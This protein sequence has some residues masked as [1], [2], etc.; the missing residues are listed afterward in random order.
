M[1]ATDEYNRS[2][3]DSGD[4]SAPAQLA[5]GG[6]LATP[7][8]SAS[9]EYSR[10]DDDAPLPAVSPEPTTSPVPPA[11]E[12]PPQTA[13]GGA[14]RITGIPP[15]ETP[16]TSTMPPP[17]TTGSSQAAESGVERSFSDTPQSLQEI[18]GSSGHPPPAIGERPPLVP[19][20]PRLEPPM[21]R[22]KDL[23]KND[24]QLFQA[25]N[26]VADA[27]NVPRRDLAA[28]VYAASNND[29]NARHGNRIGYGGLTPA[30]VEWVDPD[31]AMDP[32]DP[33]DNLF[34]TAEKLK[35]LG[36]QYGRGTPEQ[37]AAYWAGGDRVN[38][39]LRRHPDDHADI[40][41]PGTF[42]FVNR[43][44]GRPEPH[45][46]GQKSSDM[47]A[48]MA[49]TQEVLGGGAERATGGAG[50][51]SV[52]DVPPEPD[53]WWKR[54]SEAVK[55]AVGSA[56]QTAQDALSGPRA[57]GSALERIGAAPPEGMPPE[58][59][60]GAGA[61]VGSA[62]SHFGQ[63][64]SDPHL[65]GEKLAEGLG[66]LDRQIGET[67]ARQEQEAQEPPA[68][69]KAIG[70]YLQQVYEGASGNYG[71]GADNPPPAAPA[72]PPGATG[73]MVAGGAL[74]FQPAPAT[75]APPPKPT[76]LIT[77][78]QAAAP[79]PP[80]AAAP[81]PVPPIAQVAPIVPE[82]PSAAIG[83][84]STTGSGSGAAPTS[85]PVGGAGSQPTGAAPGGAAPSPPAAPQAGAAP[86]SS[87]APAVGANAPTQPPITSLPGGPS[88]ITPGGAVTAARNGGPDGVL[89]YII[90]NGAA[91]ATTGQNWRNL[92]GSLAAMM[93]AKGDI[94][95]AQHAHEYVYQL[96][97]AG[98]F[99]HLKTAY[100]AMRTGDLQQAAQE[101]AVSHSFATDGAMAGFQINNGKLYFQRFSEDTHQPLGRAQ[102]I[103]LDN[104]RGMLNITADPKTWNETLNS[105][106]TTN[107]TLEH[108]RAD[109]QLTREGQQS[110]ERIAEMERAAALERTKFVQGEENRRAQAARDQ[111][112]E[113]EQIKFTQKQG[114]IKA[115]S[116]TDATKAAD[117]IYSEAAQTVAPALDINGKP[118]DQDTRANAYSTYQG[119]AATNPNLVGP[120]LQEIVRS[121]VA[122]KGSQGQKYVFG[123][124]PATKDGGEP[125]FE[126]RDVQGRHI[127]YVPQAYLRHLL[128]TEARTPAE[129][130]RSGQ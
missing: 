104:M 36:D 9:S 56:V 52:V 113:L 51:V 70:N 88:H 75:P 74:P 37:Y 46:D 60:Q 69:L 93:I 130:A 44:V 100:N 28:V 3:D 102:E 12:A 120:K 4:T 43:V 110:R 126:I 35:R 29:Q 123:E 27:S 14:G 129:R 22:Y 39:M 97:H 101:L 78:A 47:P 6:A 92:E 116:W 41:P 118:M 25:I 112:R 68:A 32:A 17:V 57:Q 77:P 55:S 53:P 1:L 13:I 59:V 5:I 99:E 15:S 106:R 40:A 84:P 94:V 91:G 19:H 2:D 119:I 82:R 45:D 31:K 80:P 49:R 62:V 7:P 38:A 89:T 115:K 108:N 76:G 124:R 90:D 107:N 98:M 81:Q 117:A 21:Q 63:L 109:E 73:T 58:A 50:Q 48:W 83:A 23:E 67:Q 8:P 16:D 42:N 122:P 87:A 86:A 96:Q 10:S 24:P 79:P 95:G 20:T 54:G 61:A 11:P 85:P 34:M 65:L 64:V 121:L 18:M 105:E 30:D 125:E 72:P 114:E 103:T 111:Q 66:N 33:I 127:A 128:P 26:H 71:G